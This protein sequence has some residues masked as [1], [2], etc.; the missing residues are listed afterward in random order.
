MLSCLRLLAPEVSEQISVLK[1]QGTNST[2]FKSK[3][4]PMPERTL[5][6]KNVRQIL[7][8]Y[9]VGVALT[10]VGKLIEV[11]PR[12]KLVLRYGG[13]EMFTPVK[14]I[15]AMGGGKRP[16]A[17]LEA[18]CQNGRDAAQPLGWSKLAYRP[19]SFIFS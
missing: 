4:G 6:L 3:F 16:C 13:V 10:D 19:T 17:R 11:I 1:A 18:L 8:R 15:D 7:Q 9:G 5:L 12:Q 2:E 14:E